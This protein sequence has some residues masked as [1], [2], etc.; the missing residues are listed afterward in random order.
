M[1]RCGCRERFNLPALAPLPKQPRFTRSVQ[2]TQFRRLRFVPDSPLELVTIVSQEFQENC[3]VARLRPRTECVVVDPGMEPERIEEY[4]RHAGLAPAAI[5]ITHGHADH[6][7]GCEHLKRLWPQCPIIIGRDDS[8]KLRDAAKN[9]SALFGFFVTSPA[10]DQVVSEGDIYSVA[11]FDFHVL[12]VPGHSAGH[13]VY[14]WK[15]QQPFVAFVGDV[16]F[17]GSVGRTDF[18][19][20]DA[21][22]LIRHIHRKLFTLPDDTVLYPGHGPSTTVGYEKRHNPFAAL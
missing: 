9:L 6:I 4:L 3:F 7:A 18:P 22:Q 15:G 21:E 16:I 1:F 17:A 8:A 5:L 19:D 14:L 11:G 12:A 13:V 20:G 10:A 2:L